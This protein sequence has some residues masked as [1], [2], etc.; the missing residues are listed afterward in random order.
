MLASAFASIITTSFAVDD[1]ALLAR[2]E[3][4]GVVI[5]SRSRDSYWAAKDNALL[6]VDS[7]PHAFNGL[8][9]P[10]KVANA[11]KDEY[12]FRLGDFQYVCVPDDGQWKP[13]IFLNEDVV[14]K[15]P[16]LPIQIQQERCIFS[17]EKVHKLGGLRSSDH[18]YAIRSKANGRYLSYSTG[19]ES[20]IAFHDSNPSRSNSLQWI[21]HLERD[22][23]PNLGIYEALL[24]PKG[25]KKEDHPM[26][27]IK[28]G[29]K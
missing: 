19:H 18:S 26:V 15:D 7:E 24:M 23:V 11:T 14:Q 5:E 21:I 17:V 2:F 1:G 25:T 6:G 16:I 8:F 22:V 29:N 20:M 28:S 27:Y 4:Q 12:Y 10:V 9:Y 3:N 13:K